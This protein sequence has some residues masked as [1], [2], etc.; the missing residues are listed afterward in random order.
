MLQEHKVAFGNVI[1][2][3]GRST[4]NTRK[5]RGLAF[6][7]SAQIGHVTAHVNELFFVETAAGTDVWS[8]ERDDLGVVEQIADGVG[9]LNKLDRALEQTDFRCAAQRTDE[10]EPR[11]NAVRRNAAKL[12]KVEVDLSFEFF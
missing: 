6:E 12:P 3:H 7:G 2:N 8:K 10:I 4:T 5:H 11:L 9:L 1:E